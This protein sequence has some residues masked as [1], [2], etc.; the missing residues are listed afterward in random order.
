MTAPSSAPAG[1]V[2]VV[3]QTRVRPGCDEAFA[4]WQEETS[5]YIDK[6]SGF[7]GQ[8]VMRPSPPAQVDWVILQRFESSAAAINW[9]NSPE[10]LERINSAQSML[11]GRDDIHIVPDGV[12]G[13]LPSPVSVVIST[14]IKTGQEAAYRAWEQRMAA[15]QS[16]APGF[17]GY[18]FEPPIPGVQDDWLSILR[19]DSE[20]NLQ[21]WLNSPE[22]KDLLVEAEPFT[23]EF[24]AR[25]ARAGFDQWFATPSGG[26][27]Q[28]AVWKQNMIV[29]MLLYPVVFLFGYTVQV[30]VLMG[31]AGLSFPIALFIGNVVSICLLTYLVPWASGRLAWWLNPKQPS[32]KVDFGGAAILAAIYA[33]SIAAFSLLH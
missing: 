28:Q 9:L 15:A 30:P 17:E 32:S 12:S 11:V 5:G 4:L 29:L 14:R 1:S 3:V 8:T 26:Q 16:K 19:F 10:R 2:T 18:R 21:A 20:Q 23:Q 7:L 33:V 6:L 13:V 27:P 24:H 31:W 25:I 22:R